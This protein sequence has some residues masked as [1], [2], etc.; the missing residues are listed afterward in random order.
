MQQAAAAGVQSTEEGLWIGQDQEQEGEIPPMCPAHPVR[1]HLNA[2]DEV[3][4][5]HQRP[6]AEMI[7]LLHPVSPNA[8]VIS[9]STLT[10]SMGLCTLQRTG[11]VLDE[12]NKEWVPV[13]NMSE[14]KVPLRLHVG[15]H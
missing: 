13:A 10:P 7:V 12:D 15:L 4:C 1:P 3:T 9:S 14:F 5:M 11:P 2:A 8:C 6:P